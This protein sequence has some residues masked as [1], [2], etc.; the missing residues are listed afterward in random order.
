MNAFLC[1]LAATAA[2]EVL[3]SLGSFVRVLRSIRRLMMVKWSQVGSNKVKVDQRWCKFGLVGD[4]VMKGYFGSG[5]KLWLEVGR[6]GERW[7]DVG[8]G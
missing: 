7:E 1:F 6:N 8:R 5:E 4:W 3:L 2:Q